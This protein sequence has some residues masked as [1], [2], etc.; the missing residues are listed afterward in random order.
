MK[1]EWRNLMSTVQSQIVVQ[2]SESKSFKLILVTRPL[3]AY[4]VIAFVGTWLLDAPMVLGKDGLGLFDYSVPLPIYIFLFLLSAY[5]GPTLAALLVTNVR[6]GREGIQAFLRRYRIWLV[7]ARWYLIALLGYPLLYVVVAMCWLGTAALHGVVAHWSA[8]FT[9]YLPGILILPGIITWGEEAGWRGFALTHMQQGGGALK[10]SLVVGFLHGVWHLPAFLL[11]NGPV[12]GGPFSIYR[13]ALSTAII[14]VVTVI[15]TW[16]FNNAAQSILIAVLIHASSDAV[17]PLMAR[18]V[19]DFPKQASYTVLGMYVVIALVLIAV[20]K[21]T[22][23]LK[24]KDE[25]RN[26]SKKEKDM[27]QYQIAVSKIID[28]NPADIYGVMSD[29]KVGHPAILPK[30][31]FSK[32][33]VLEGGQGAGTVIEVHMEVYGTKRVFH[34]VVSEPEP[35]HLLV[36]KDAEAGV[37]TTFTV[38]PLDGGKQSNVMISTISRTAPGMPGFLERLFTPL[39]IRRIYEQELEN[40]DKYVRRNL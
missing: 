13:F 24:E 5:T 11:V 4:F 37:T 39:I 28:A 34:Q 10:A 14:M 19:P 21:G 31:F 36:E 27:N 8:F 33:I 20:T 30:A 6:E 35:G 3:T 26:T 40:L 15:W 17:Q 2:P 7:G 25:F 16:V 18:W 9:V 1:Y 23:S 12:A 38:E 32:L 22:L 29:Y